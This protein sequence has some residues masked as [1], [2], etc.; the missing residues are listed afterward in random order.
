M[1]KENFRE[2]AHRVADWMADYLDG[3]EKLPVKP[4]LRP[5][6]IL[7]QLPDSAPVH[8]EEFA[9]VFQDF[10]DIILPGLFYLLLVNCPKSGSKSTPSCSVSPSAKVRAM[11]SRTKS[12]AAWAA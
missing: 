6:E 4:D 12:A 1:I 8:G 9:S 7:S 2:N 11:Q 3:I 5:G 10:K